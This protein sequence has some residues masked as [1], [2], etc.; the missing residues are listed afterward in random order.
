M[1]MAIKQ[2]G[3]IAGLTALEAMRQ[4]VVL[5]L[6]TCCTAFIALLPT[7]VIFS[8]GDGQRLVR[9]SSLSLHLVCGLILGGYAACATLNREL[10]R[11]TASAVLSK[12]VDRVLF[13]LAKYAGVGAVVLLFSATVTGASIISTRTAANDFRL[14]WWSATPLLIAV[15]GAYLVGSLQNFLFRVPFVSRTMGLLVLAVPLA[16]AFSCLFDEEG[17]RVA[18]GSTMPWHLLPACALNTLAVL[19]MAGIAVSLA[20]RLD[21]VPTL[22][23]LS[24]VFIAGLVSDYLFGRIAPQHAWADVVHRLVPNWQHFWVVDALAREGIPWS[25][26]AQAGLYAA[27]YLA[28]ILCLGI[29]A[30]QR[31]E[32]EG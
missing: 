20:T 7:L 8:L 13:F 10:R 31:T 9:D 6:A 23:I 30:L 19:L 16:L 27:F 17:R 21:V 22:S 3:A 5:L 26:V 11:G 12:P 15:L 18:F 32:I 4:P 29:V 28:A 2:F 14:D 25:Y 24:L 1:R